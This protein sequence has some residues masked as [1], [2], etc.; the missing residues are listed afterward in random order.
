MNSFLFLTVC[1]C[2]TNALASDAG[3]KAAAEILLAGLDETADPCDDFYKY[4]CGNWPATHNGT[5]D[6]DAVIIRTVEVANALGEAMANMDPNKNTAV[7]S[8]YD[9]AGILM[10]DCLYGQPSA[11]DDIALANNANKHLGGWP[12]V[13][14]QMS[15]VPGG[16]MGVEAR[17]Y[18]HFL[19]SPLFSAEM[20]RSHW[21]PEQRQNMML[22]SANVEFTL[23]DHQPIIPQIDEVEKDYIRIVSRLQRHMNISTDMATLTADA[24]AVARLDVLV[25]NASFRARNWTGPQVLSTY[26]SMA[27]EAT[28]FRHPYNVM[29]ALNKWPFIN[30]PQ[31]FITLA[32]AD[33][34]PLV[35]VFGSDFHVAY[36]SYIDW[37]NGMFVTT[38]ERIV[39]NWQLFTMAKRYESS[40]Q[41]AASVRVLGKVHRFTDNHRPTRAGLCALDLLSQIPL[42]TGRIY[43][44][45]SNVDQ[46][47]MDALNEIVGATLTGWRG[48]ISEVLWMSETSKQHAYDK[49]ANTMRNVAWPAWI[50]NDAALADYYKTFDL[51]ATDDAFTLRMKRARF[52][53]ATKLRRFGEPVDRGEL[54]WYQSAAHV[55]TFYNYNL[56]SIVISAAIMSSPFFNSNYPKAYNYAHIGTM[57]GQQLAH[58]FDSQGGFYGPIGEYVNGSWFDPQSMDGFKQMSQ[59]VMDEYNSLCLT[60]GGRQYCVN[61]ERTLIENIAD[62]GGL[63]AS[64]RAF[65]AMINLQGGENKLP[66]GYQAVSKLTEDQLFW[67]SF[68]NAWCSNKP[69]AVVI[70]EINDDDQSPNPIRVL[71]TLRNVPEFASAFNCKP[72]SNMAP[73][74]HCHVWVK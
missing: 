59:C 72:G 44:D 71:G 20:E 37:V 54:G 46:E 69:D 61:G 65:K 68:G 51:T 7:K 16:A 23:I 8:P 1:L 17:L 43:A 55:D 63:V 29:T 70:H 56:N 35:N 28:W 49:I 45:A 50:M 10:H 58:A 22:R 15:A 19:T 67:F 27:Q 3:F 60:L 9:R 47:D 62:N 39:R 26:E 48:M 25:A 11:V 36:P 66:A 18:T 64:Y 2:A 31:Y 14:G 6:S 4:S 30:W 5:G 34:L 73:V 52:D 40:R 57:M 42:L 74:D 24:G 13:D 33:H 38:D 41:Q 21:Q 53:S 12:S 32:S